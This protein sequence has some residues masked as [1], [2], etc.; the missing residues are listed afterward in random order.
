MHRFS[1]ILLAA[2]VIFT[3]T[4]CSVAKDIL[5]EEK[6]NELTEKINTAWEQVGKDAIGDLTDDA[7]REFGFGKSFD[8]PSE[9]VGATLPK[10]R[11][12]NVKSCLS[13]KESGHISLSAVSDADI[14]AYLQKLYGIGYEKAPKSAPFDT[15]V[16]FDGTYVGLVR[17]GSSDCALVFA[18]S[19]EKLEKLA[20]IDEN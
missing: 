9:G 11:D 5:G 15:V 13:D 10:F 20:H 3:M 6:Y 1:L 7:W 4:G 14:E 16:V 2:L 18:P 12:A 8:W 17:L 19:L